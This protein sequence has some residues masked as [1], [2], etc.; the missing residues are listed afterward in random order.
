MNPNYPFIYN[1]TCRVENDIADAWL[2]WMRTT[3]IPRVLSTGLFTQQRI[4]LLLDTGDPGGRTFAVQYA[5]TDR[6]AYERYLAEHAAGLRSEAQER[7]G[8]SVVSF[9]TIMEVIN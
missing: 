2:E 7:W 6:D 5:T 4:L 3:H 9:R 8:E 1:V